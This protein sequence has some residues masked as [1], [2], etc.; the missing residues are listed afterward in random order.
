MWWAAQPGCCRWLACAVPVIQPFLILLTYSCDKNQSE[1]KQSKEDTGKTS[2]RCTVSVRADAKSD[3]E[4]FSY[5]SCSG[6]TIE[7]ASAFTVVVAS[8][9]GLP[10]ST[11]HCKVCLCPAT[12]VTAVWT[13]HHKTV[14][15]EPGMMA[16]WGENSRSWRMVRRRRVSASWS[17]QWHWEIIRLPKNA[18]ELS[19][20]SHCS[21]A[22]R[23]LCSCG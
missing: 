8:N 18:S 6:F 12:A 20:W 22:Q 5:A 19:Q 11:T 17:C 23:E 21:Q 14:S 4:V 10:V 16:R 1:I 9:V 15:L 13:I 2:A 7:L 3:C